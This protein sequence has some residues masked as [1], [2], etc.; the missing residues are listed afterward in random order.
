[1]WNY[2]FMYL[3]ASCTSEI[4]ISWDLDHVKGWMTLDFYI[5]VV[6]VQGF[7]LNYFSQPTGHEYL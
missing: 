5:L 4:H 2:F 6:E 3:S 1:M 7:S